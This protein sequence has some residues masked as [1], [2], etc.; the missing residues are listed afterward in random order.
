VY[1]IPH[2]RM[3]LR[4]IRAIGAGAARN[5]SRR[6]QHVY[7]AARCRTGLGAGRLVAAGA[8]RQAADAAEQGSQRALGRAGLQPGAAVAPGKAAGSYGHAPRGPFDGPPLA[9]L[10]DGAND[11][12]TDIV[13]SPRSRGHRVRRMAHVG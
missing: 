9:F 6:G 10:A 4:G 13:R 1:A 7:A 8:Q 3:L 5:R 2:T 11:A 12:T